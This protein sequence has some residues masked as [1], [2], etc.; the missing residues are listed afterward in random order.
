[1]SKLTQ[2]A[3]KLLFNESKN[4]SSKI[5]MPQTSIDRF[6]KILKNEWNRLQKRFSAD[7]K[8]LLQRVSRKDVLGILDWVIQNS[9]E[10]QNLLPDHPIRIPASH[11]RDRRRYYFSDH[12][13]FHH[14]FRRRN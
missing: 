13:P 11:P 8:P 1:M 14:D 5:M 2:I 7:Y 4:V 6:I 10:W 9:D 12:Y 3:A